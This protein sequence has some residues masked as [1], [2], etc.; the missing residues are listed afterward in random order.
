VPL[1]CACS[2]FNGKPL[3]QAPSGGSEP[4]AGIVSQKRQFEN[5]L[6]EHLEVLISLL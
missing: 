6:M 2:Q 1:F 5:T 4:Q 3:G